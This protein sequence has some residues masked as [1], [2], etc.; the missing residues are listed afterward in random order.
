MSLIA[1]V[2]S[3]MFPHAIHHQ[4]VRSVIQECYSLYQWNTIQYVIPVLPQRKLHL[5]G[6]SNVDWA[7]CPDNRCSTS[8]YCIFLRS[9]CLRV[10][11]SKPQYHYQAP[12]LSVLQWS[13]QLQRSP[14]SL[15]FLEALGFLFQQ[16]LPCFVSIATLCIL[17]LKI[18]SMLE[19]YSRVITILSGK[20]LLLG[21]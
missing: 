15:I 20:R 6:F 14:G 18:F 9:T 11:R 8:S 10:Q 5:Y 19:R 17:L 2:N 13:K 16:D 21:L 12:K 7:V 1:F 4:A 3:C